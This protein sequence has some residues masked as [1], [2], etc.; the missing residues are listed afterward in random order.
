MKTLALAA[1]IASLSLTA[2]ALDDATI[3]EKIVELKDEDPKV[4]AAALTELTPILAELI[5]GL[6]NAQKDKDPDVVEAFKE[7][8]KQICAKTESTPAGKEGRMAANEVA[9]AACCKVFC[10]AQDLYRRTD[11]NKDGVLEYAQD[12]KSLYE[13]TPGTGDIALID[14]AMM[15]T[16][17]EPGTAKPKNGYLLKVLTKQGEN[18]TGGE[19]AFITNGHMTLGYAIVAYPT[20]YGKTGTHT[21]LVSNAGT[22]YMKDLGDETVSI[23]SKM[24]A[25]DPDKDWVVKE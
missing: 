3:Q 4:R 2:F 18:A 20:E 19:R 12:L 24:T 10:T 8:D 7:C 22:V 23:G 5:S 16:E 9:A 13:I 25:F 17:G 1:M 6:A 11:Y 14:K 21:F 15:E